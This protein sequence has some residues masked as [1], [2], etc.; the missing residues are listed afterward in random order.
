MVPSHRSHRRY[1]YMQLCDAQGTQSLPIAHVITQ[2]VPC[3][4]AEQGSKFG[5]NGGQPAQPIENLMNRGGQPALP[6]PHRMHQL[7]EDLTH[8][9]QQEAKERTG[10]KPQKAAASLIAIRQ[11]RFAQIRREARDY[12][13]WQERAV[14]LPGSVY[15]SEQACRNRWRLRNLRRHRQPC[16]S[17]KVVWGA[18]RP[19]RHAC[20]L[21]C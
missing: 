2:C 1:R 19:L 21:C 20:M 17:G 7:P 13:I 3:N 10:G 12:Y 14:G 11:Q 4:G 8:Q 6:I 9:T 18:P 16:S 15:T 5:N